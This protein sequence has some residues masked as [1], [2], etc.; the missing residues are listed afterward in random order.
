LRR[1]ILKLD[2]HKFK[3]KDFFLKPGHRRRHPAAP[4]ENAK[5]VS[6]C[7]KRK[8]LFKP[9]DPPMSDSA[10]PLVVRLTEILDALPATERRFAEALLE[11][12][13]DLPTHT[14]TELAR[15]FDVSNATVT[16]L[17][18]R[19]G[20]DSYNEARRQVRIE[21]QAGSPLVLRPH[22][23]ADAGA[24]QLHLERWLSNLTGTF[25]A[26]PADTVER[27][28]AAMVGAQAVWFAGFRANHCLAS[29]L[30]WQVLRVLARAHVIPGPGETLA[31]H[32]AS[33]AEQDMLV[34]FALRRTM[35][36]SAALLRQARRIGLRSLCI[37]DSDTADTGPATWVIRCHTHAA[38]ALDSHVAVM[39]LVHL[40]ANRVLELSGKAGRR[41]LSKIEQAHGLLDDLR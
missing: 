4:R 1:R 17:I 30:R 26:L 12:P 20:Y 34:V 28:A 7:S 38:G 6:Q 9:G 23:A 5:R 32:A 29:Y 10:R 11:Y 13:G 2:F 14:A 16:R 39:A 35:A 8:A 33:M 22:A 40:L 3:K 24:L 15:R 19:L 36:P 37:T 25:D 31:E 41:R 18:R 27:A 21:Q